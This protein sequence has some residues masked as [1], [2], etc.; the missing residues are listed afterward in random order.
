MPDSVRAA[1]FIDFD[2]VYSSLRQI[3]PQAADFFVQEPLAW[4][5]WFERGGHAVAEPTAEGE[6][7]AL[8][9][10]ERRRVLLRR[11]YLNPQAFWRQRAAFVSAGFQVV[12]CPQLT[13]GGKNSADIV[14]AL[15]LVETLAHETRFDEFLLLSGDADF[16]P[17]LLRLR[18]HDRRTTIL[19]NDRIAA[20]LRNAADIV[21]PL[22]RFLARALGIEPAAPVAEADETEVVASLRRRLQ[23]SPAP[24]PLKE[25]TEALVADFGP[26]LRQGW[27]GHRSLG[28]LVKARLAP[29]VEVAGQHAYM[30]G[31]HERPS[32]AEAAPGAPGAAPAADPDQ[33]ALIERVTEATGVPALSGETYDA[34][35]EALAEAL[36][37]GARTQSDVV[38][39]ASR[40][41][42]DEGQVVGDREIGF[43]FY[44]F[45]LARLDLEAL[46]GDREA[47]AEA[48]RE[49]LRHRCGER[50]L[51]LDEDE[52]AALDDWLLGP[53]DETAGG[54][55]EEEPGLP[56]DAAAPAPDPG[57]AR[58]SEE[59]L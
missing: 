25:L 50:G 54:G 51:L 5:Q 35:F 49:N 48:F 10:A 21:V 57:G 32:R 44:G 34:V 3:D 20:A 40:R 45:R 13:Q 23:D 38:A 11:C 17:V 33:A 7:A 47:V 16:A 55:T 53:L 8:E 30:P 14:M 28:R 18:A 27:L 6:A 42:Q 26:Q 15:D 29:E 12:D 9:G 4:L 52:E 24:V 22:E 1:L 39:R 46:A 37:A 56:F 59:S 41:L 2:N 36:A 58:P 43:V 31:R 19:A